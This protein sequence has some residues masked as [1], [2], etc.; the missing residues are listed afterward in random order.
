VNVPRFIRRL[1]RAPY[2]GLRHYSAVQEG[3]LYRSGQP[4]PEQLAEL[5]QRHDLKTVVALRGSRNPDDPDSWEQ[6]ER[7]T[8]QSHGVE[9]LALPSNHKNPPTAEQVEQFLN[10]M[11]DESRH[12]VLIHCRIGQ[13]RTG[14]YC[15]LFRVH[16]Q[17][18]DPEDALR[19]MDDMGFNIRHRRHQR[20]L[21]AYRKF[22]RSEH[23]SGSVV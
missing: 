6:D 11:R 10:V 3:V 5:I 14:M 20:L 21:E 7:A 1:F 17:G 22:A 18:V 12:P 19:E 13:Q 8:C 4:T 23:V 9:F 16:L 2:D 15:A